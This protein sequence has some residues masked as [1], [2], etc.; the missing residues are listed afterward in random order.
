M[1]QHAISHTQVDHIVPVTG[2]APL[3]VRLAATPIDERV[4]RSV[5][6]EQVHVEVKVAME[7]N[8]IDAGL[9]RVGEPSPFACPECH[10]VLLRMKD[11][12]QGRF[13]CHTGHSYTA[14]SLLAAVNEQIE[15]SIW[16][17]IR[18]LEEGRLLLCTLADHVA[19][20]HSATDAA[21]LRARADET[22]RQA[23]VLRQLL[24]AREPLS[25][26]SK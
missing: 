26:D 24:T 9:E 1:P 16:N 21:E 7:E 5:V 22:R 13:R 4:A 19:T 25:L 6:P 12:P 20:A 14:L 10:G 11:G 8:P 2:I 17:S 18:S 15:A 3:L 23:D